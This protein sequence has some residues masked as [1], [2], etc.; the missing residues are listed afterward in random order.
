M[1][2]WR[3]TRQSP[4]FCVACR[5]D[6]NSSAPL[7]VPQCRHTCA[8]PVHGRVPRRGTRQRSRQR[9]AIRH[10]ENLPAA[11]FDGSAPPLG[12]VRVSS[13]HLG[14]IPGAR[15]GWA[16]QVGRRSSVHRRRDALR[17][18]RKPPCASPRHT[19]A[20]TRNDAGSLQCSLC[21]RGGTRRPGLFE[22]RIHCAS[23]EAQALHVCLSGGTDFYFRAI[24]W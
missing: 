8:S 10:E 11:G 7:R 3:H 24:W 23:L 4:F 1:P 14:L 18:Q 15:R 16:D 21:L 13:K 6:A 20:G 17:R 9:A 19:C 2:L 22:A 12:S 5:A